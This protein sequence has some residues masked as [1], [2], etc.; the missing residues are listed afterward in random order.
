MFFEWLAVK[1]LEIASLQNLAQ[2]ARHSQLKWDS[3]LTNYNPQILLPHIWYKRGIASFPHSTTAV[4]YKS[5]TLLNY[6]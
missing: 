1:A 4:V 2:R 3:I 5:V 6:M